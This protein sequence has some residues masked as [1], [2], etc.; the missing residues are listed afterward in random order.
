LLKFYY[1]RLMCLSIDYWDCN[2]SILP[3]KRQK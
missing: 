1:F 2:I 3:L